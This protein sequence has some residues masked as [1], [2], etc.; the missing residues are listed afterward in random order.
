MT[1][2]YWALS[3]IQGQTKP[4][5][6]TWQNKDLTGCTVRY[7]AKNSPADA[8][9][10]L[11]LTDANGGV[12]W[13]TRAPSGKFSLNFTPTITANIAEGTS[14]HLVWI[15]FPTGESYPLLSGPLQVSKG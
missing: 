13:I 9:N 10:E 11:L 1:P 7:I 15:D 6:I 4:V 5:K 3:L 12:S 2:G 14:D 8:G